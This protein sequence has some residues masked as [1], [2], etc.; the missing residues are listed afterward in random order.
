MIVV[1]LRTRPWEQK[2]AKLWVA[3]LEKSKKKR[4]VKTK[5]Y[6]GELGSDMIMTPVLGSGARNACWCFLA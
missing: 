5:G 3:P 2:V 6:I 4:K 1:V